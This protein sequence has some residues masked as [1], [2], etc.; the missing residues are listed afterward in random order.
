[1]LAHACSHTHTHS[2]VALTLRRL[3]HLRRLHID[4]CVLG[5][6]GLRLLADALCRADATLRH[7]ILGD[8]GGRGKAGPTVDVVRRCHSLTAL[9][10]RGSFEND[11]RW[12]QDAMQTVFK[13][14]R[15]REPHAHS[16][17]IAHAVLV[18]AYFVPAEDVDR[19]LH[20]AWVARSRD[21]MATESFRRNQE[22]LEV[23]VYDSD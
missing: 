13:A 16:M 23:V 10:L 18:P 6:A 1:M 4:N 5:G 21:A 7:L 15:D 11:L 2:A 20:R 19:M 9:E 3:P 17:S 8:V 14:L 22:P 12:G